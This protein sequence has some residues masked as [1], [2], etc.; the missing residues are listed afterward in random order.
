MTQYVCTTLQARQA[1]AAAIVQF[2]I[3]S[4]VLIENAAHAIYDVLQNR[5]PAGSKEQSVA[6][7][8]G[9]GGNAS[10][11]LALARLLLLD[12]TPVALFL[13]KNHLCTDAA[14]E[15]SILLSMKKNCASLPLQ[16]F[17]R[18]ELLD[19]DNTFK[20]EIASLLASCCWV[21]DALC[22]T[23][24]K[25]PLRSEYIRLIDALNALPLHTLAIDLPSGLTPDTGEACGTVFRADVTVALDCLK[26]GLL[27]NEGRKSAG[28]VVL[29]DIGIP[30]FIHEED[31]SAILV[32]QPLIELLLPPRSDRSNKGT[33]GKVFMIGGSTDMQGA[34]D[35]AAKAC[36][37]SGCGTLTLF[38]PKDAAA[39]IRAKCSMAMILDGAQDARGYFSAAAGVQLAGRAI[40]FSTLAIGNGMGRGEGALCVLENAIRC[41]L[42]CVYDADAI[43]LLGTNPRLQKKLKGILTPH[44]AEF[45]SLCGVKMSELG[46][47]PYLYAQQWAFEHPDCVLLV[48][49]D[50]S[51]I[52]SKSTCYVINRPDSALAKGGSGDVLCGVVTGLYAS[53]LPAPNA[54]IAG[55]WIHNQAAVYAQSPWSFTPEKL[56]AHLGDVFETLRPAAAQKDSRA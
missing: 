49:S 32:D 10:D 17:E 50:F 56:I 12:G 35:L 2:G 31:G 40:N 8:C 34:L 11:G 42:P 19:A 4:L 48:K 33:F 25:N 16:I 30:S 29:A 45:S 21:V 28:E 7:F 6:I 27:L 5:R 51:L 53:G 46:K 38:A 3:P 41:N 15:Y 13:D 43:R 47:K 44:L 1:D 18:N 37:E 22:G 20:P 14:V 55:A 23:G 24:I 36:Y 26:W 54:A 9:S 52:C 39:A